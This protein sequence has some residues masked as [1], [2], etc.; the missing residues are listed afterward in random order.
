MMK[1]SALFGKKNQSGR[2]ENNSTNRRPMKFHL[3]EK[4]KK[5]IEIDMKIE[6]VKLSR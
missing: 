6:I 1:S 5:E 2:I 3:K 4:K